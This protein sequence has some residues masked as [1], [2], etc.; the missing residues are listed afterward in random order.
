MVF[1]VVF[2]WSGLSTGKEVD[3]PLERWLKAKGVEIGFNSHTKAFAA[4]GSAQDRLESLVWAIGDFS[5]WLE[6][7]T[8]V[9]AG[10]NDKQGDKATKS[11]S[12]RSMNRLKG[13][14]V[15]LITYLERPGGSERAIVIRKDE[16]LICMAYKSRQEGP[17]VNR[18]HSFFPTVDGVRRAAVEKELATAF[19][20]DSFERVREDGEWMEC[21]FLF[22]CNPKGHNQ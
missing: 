14:D 5:E 3:D 12:T 7:E 20:K 17:P 8:Q 10:A 21:I 11:S 9:V 15:E 2:S 22:D 19:V 4:R 18:I 6:C 16:R 1:V 13:Y